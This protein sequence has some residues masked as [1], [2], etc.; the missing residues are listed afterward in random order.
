MWYPRQ[1][2]GQRLAI[3]FSATT[4]AGAFGGVLAYLIHHMD[5]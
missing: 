5:G 2:Q 3:F 4:L 1:I